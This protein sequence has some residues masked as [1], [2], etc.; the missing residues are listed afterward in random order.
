ME[1]ESAAAAPA[2]RAEQHA[3]DCTAPSDG[4]VEQP[5]SGFITPIDSKKRK[6]V[7]VPDGLVLAG[8]R[9]V[10]WNVREQRKVS[11]NAA[12]MIKNLKSYLKRHPDR[13]IYAGQDESIDRVARAQSRALAMLAKA[14]GADPPAAAPSSSAAVAAAVGAVGAAVDDADEMSA[15]PQPM[16]DD[17]DDADENEVSLL[18]RHRAARCAPSFPFIRTNSPSPELLPRAP[19]YPLGFG[20]R[21]AVGDGAHADCDD[22]DAVS[23]EPDTSEPSAPLSPP[24]SPSLF[25]A[26]WADE[27]PEPEASVED[28]QDSHGSTMDTHGDEHECSAIWAEDENDKPGAISPCCVSSVDDLFVAARA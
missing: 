7:D 26:E 10:M 20:G 18:L 23:L 19:F 16:D 1:G 8:E 4:K 3:S 15:D 14:V 24:G 17:D 6:P 22:D 13:E 28:K 9:V 21:C 5:A 27:P 25:L 2:E 12:P 11:G